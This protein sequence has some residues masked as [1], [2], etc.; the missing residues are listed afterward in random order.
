VH[1]RLCFESPHDVL[2]VGHSRHSLGI[3]ER[4]DLDVFEARLGK[5]FDQLDLARGRDRAFL[6]LKAFARPFFPDAD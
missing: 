1:A 2:G 6:D 4:D 5:C 3:D